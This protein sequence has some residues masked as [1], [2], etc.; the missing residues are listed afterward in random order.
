MKGPYFADDDFRHN[1]A[2][3]RDDWHAERARHGRHLDAAWRRSAAL[4]QTD[5]VAR[6]HAGFG[7]GTAGRADADG[8]ALAGGSRW[9]G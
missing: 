5:A 1:T 9:F 6:D 7:A 4:Q 3:P 8:P 2:R